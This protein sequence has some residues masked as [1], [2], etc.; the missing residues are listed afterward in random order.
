MAALK[1]ADFKSIRGAFKF[2]NNNFGIQ[3]F[4]LLEVAKDRGRYTLKTGP[5]IMPSMMDAYHSQCPMK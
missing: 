2:N 1:A 4:Y 5:K 3:D